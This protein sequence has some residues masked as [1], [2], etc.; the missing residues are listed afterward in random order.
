M[1]MSITRINIKLALECVNALQRH[2]EITF[3][4]LCVL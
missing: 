3:K 2:H 4:L 1:D